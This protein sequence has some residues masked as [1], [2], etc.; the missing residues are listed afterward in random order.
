MS[1]FKIEYA[2][3]WLVGLLFLLIVGLGWDYQVVNP[4]LRF[5]RAA[6]DQGQWWRIV[7]CNLV[8]LGHYH[9]ALNMAGLLMLQYFFHDVLSVRV[10]L[11]ALFIGFTGTGLAL[12][13]LNPELASYVGIS[14]ALHGF[15]LLALI[16][17]WQQTPVLNTII[18]A[19][20]VGRLIWEQTPS[21][22]VNYMQ[23]YIHGRVLVDAH[24]YGSVL[25]VLT[26]LLF[27]PWDA[28]WARPAR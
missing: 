12:Y 2:H 3:H 26:S 17:S 14:G 24:L 1:P 28:R 11:A 25:G 18:I 8:H 13:W 22:D 10:W 19:L 5:D 21:Y 9:L 7:T 23:D 16:L 15:F 6:I 20:V 4:Y 27:K